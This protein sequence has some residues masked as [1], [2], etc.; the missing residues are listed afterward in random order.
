MALADQQ[1]KARVELA[2]QRTTEAKALASLQIEKA[3]IAAEKATAEADLGP[4]R[5]LATLLNPTARITSD[6]T[7]SHSRG[8]KRRNGVD[9]RL[10]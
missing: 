8:Q 5:Y 7:F 4:V 1:H 6:A 9:T 10:R 2:S 3:A